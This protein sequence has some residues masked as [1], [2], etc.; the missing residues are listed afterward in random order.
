MVS[1]IHQKHIISHII[2]LILELESNNN[3]LN[4]NQGKTQYNHAPSKLKCFYCEGEQIIKECE[5]SK[6]D[7][8]KCK[9]K[10]ADIAQRY[11]D[12]ILQKAKKEN[13]AINETMFW[14]RQQESMYSIE[15]A[16]LLL[17]NMYFSNSRSV[18]EW[19]NRHVQNVIINE[20]HSINAILYKVK[21]HGVEVEALYDT[22]TSIS[23]MSKC[24]LDNF[25]SKPKSPICNRNISGMVGK[26]LIPLE[27]CF[28]QF[29]RGKRIFHDRVIVIDN[30]MCNY[31]LG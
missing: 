30:L 15:Q 25:Q 14:S 21:V 1:I 27:E 23:V 22:G 7:K 29:Q 12:R 24:F 26:A 9:L 10:T 6:Q 5:N 17:G 2:V 16:E 13:I 18:W 31:I 11:K 28:I 3:K 8:A 20:V 19:L 4:R